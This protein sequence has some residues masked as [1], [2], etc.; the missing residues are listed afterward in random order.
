MLNDAPAALPAG[1]HKITF[2]QAL[3]RVLWLFD[4]A[5]LPTS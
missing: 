3:K 2:Y 1:A 4:P 5:V